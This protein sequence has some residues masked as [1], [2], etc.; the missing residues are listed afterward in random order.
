MLLLFLTL[1]LITLITH[2]PT[3]SPNS[4]LSNIP[5]CFASENFHTSMSRPSNGQPSRFAGVY[6]IDAAGVTRVDARNCSVFAKKRYSRSMCRGGLFNVTKAA[7]QRTAY[8][9]V[10][11]RIAARSPKYVKSVDR[12]KK[13]CYSAS[14]HASLLPPN[15]TQPTSRHCC[16]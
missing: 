9:M 5:D 7:K 13:V 3:H 11:L 6:R 1:T 4:G 8:L 16:V 15:L 14:N 2:S 12:P 10:D